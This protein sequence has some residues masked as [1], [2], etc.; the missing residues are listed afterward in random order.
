MSVHDLDTQAG[1]LEQSELAWV[2]DR[3][4][5]VYVD[6]VPVRQD[7]LG[8]V[9]KVGLLLR[10]RDSGTLTRAI[11]SGRVLLGERVRDALWR[12]LSKDLGPEC[13]PQIPVSPAPFTVAEYFPDPTRTGF[14]DPRHHAVSLAYIV[15]ING[16]VEPSSDTLQFTWLTPGEAISPEIALEMSSGHDRLVALALA[17]AG[18]TP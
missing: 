6:A 14:S 17:H 8:R 7:H 10:A 4:P 11:V 15:P 5:L 13:D 12:H 9:E 16:Q 3:V 1:W 18:V 2:S